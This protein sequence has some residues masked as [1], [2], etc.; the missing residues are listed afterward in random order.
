MRT[1]TVTVL[2]VDDDKVDVT[3]VKRAFK[4]LRIANP[5]VVAKDGIDALDVLRGTNGR[6]KL[7]PPYLIL[8]DLNMPRMSGIEFLD[9]LRQDPALKSTVVFVLTTS[10]AE[11]DRLKAQAKCISGYVLKSQA[12]KSFIEAISMIEHYWKIIEFPVP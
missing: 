1:E 4:D 12:G 6:E 10:D 7:P 2:L 11:Q 9:A 3:A 8:L 5:L